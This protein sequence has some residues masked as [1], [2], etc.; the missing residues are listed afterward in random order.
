MWNM[1]SFRAALSNPACFRISYILWGF[2]FIFGALPHA[3]TISCPR[4]CIIQVVF[5]G[6]RMCEAVL[7]LCTLTLGAMVC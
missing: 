5:R 7:R 3:P 2:A 6:F 1:K 4:I